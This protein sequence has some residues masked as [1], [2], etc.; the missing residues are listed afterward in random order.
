M[1]EQ[2]TERAFIEPGREPYEAEQREAKLVRAL[3]DHLRSIGHKV[4][5]YR[6]LPDGELK[7]LY[8]DLV[9]GTSK[10]LVEAKGTVTREAFRMAIGQLADYSRFL[11]D[12]TRTIFV[13]EEPRADLLELA[14]SVS[15]TVVWPAGSA[16][17]GIPD[18]P[19]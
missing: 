13:P 18:V 7:P 9:D 4:V 3:R 19:W 11:T 6:I 16:D 17:Q 5:R 15:V 10:V 14:A 2:Y 1:E 8:A 12:S